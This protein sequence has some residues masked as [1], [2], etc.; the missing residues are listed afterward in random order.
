[1]QKNIEENIG[2][3]DKEKKNGHLQKKFPA[4]NLFIIN[5]F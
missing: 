3:Y 1:M 2:N 5:I 4:I